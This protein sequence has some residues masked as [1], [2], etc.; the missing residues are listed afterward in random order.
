[1]A[2]A[3]DSVDSPG[4][5]DNQLTVIQKCGCVEQS[6]ELRIEDERSD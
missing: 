3:D 6:K 1:M 2:S 4:G 5:T